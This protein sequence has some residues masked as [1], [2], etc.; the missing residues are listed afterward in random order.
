MFVLRREARFLFLNNSATNGNDIL[1]FQVYEVQ[2][3]ALWVGALA[4]GESIFGSSSLVIL[5]MREP[6][7]VYSIYL[8]YSVYSG[9]QVHLCTF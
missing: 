9:L 4:F 3:S 2:Q 7:Q 1:L 8:E 6:L 5:Q